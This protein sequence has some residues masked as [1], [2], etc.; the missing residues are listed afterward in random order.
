MLLYL[1]IMIIIIMQ[2]RHKYT[3]NA[4]ATCTMSCRLWFVFFHKLI[5][6]IILWRTIHT[7]HHNVV[8]LVSTQ[9][10]IG[11]GREIDNTNL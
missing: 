8:H 3:C 5:I 10:Y 1:T 9:E 7:H 2:K 6:T 11:C 4:H